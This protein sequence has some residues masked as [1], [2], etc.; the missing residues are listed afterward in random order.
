MRRNAQAHRQTHFDQ[1]EQHLEFV[2]VQRKTQCVPTDQCT[3]GSGNIRHAHQRVGHRYRQF[4]DLP[5][6]SHIAKIEYAHNTLHIIFIDYE[7]V[8]IRIAVNDRHPHGRQTRLH[9]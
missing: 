4:I 5:G 1:I 7:V 8:I 9:L 3:T 2:F 6:V